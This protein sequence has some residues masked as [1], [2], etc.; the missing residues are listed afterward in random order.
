MPGYLHECL[1]GAMAGSERLPRFSNNRRMYGKGLRIS[2]IGRI[3]LALLLVPYIALVAIEIIFLPGTKIAYTG[4][5]AD[6]LGVALH[7][8]SLLPAGIATGGDVHSIYSRFFIALQ[9]WLAALCAKRQPAV[10]DQP[11]RHVQVDALEPRVVVSQYDLVRA[12]GR[13]PG[14]PRAVDGGPA[15]INRPLW[16]PFVLFTI[17]ST[18]L[19]FGGLASN[20]FLRGRKIRRL[21][22]E[23][24]LK[25][26]R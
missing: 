16:L 3:Y 1:A 7:T 13:P 8:E 4:K 18:W 9:L 14:R 15:G 25:V 12:R 22:G 6:L 10:G 24:K 19:V 5:E 26:G 11:D 23:G 20:S 21:L 2:L 17:A